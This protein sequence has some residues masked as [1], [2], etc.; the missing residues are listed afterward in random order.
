MTAQLAGMPGGWR[1][2]T[3]LHC[4]KTISLACRKPRSGAKPVPAATIT[5]GAALF[6]GSRK[7]ATC[8]DT[9]VVAEMLTWRHMACYHLALNMCH[10]PKQCHLTDWSAWMSVNDEVTVSGHAA[11]PPA[12]S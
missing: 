2:T 3:T 9:N 11:G 7:V 1:Y 5:T 4:T 6:I 8:T 10:R 12:Q